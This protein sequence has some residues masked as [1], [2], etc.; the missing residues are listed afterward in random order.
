MLYIMDTHTYIYIYIPAECADPQTEIK[1]RNC[2]DQTFQ[3][4]PAHKTLNVQALL[5]SLSAESR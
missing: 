5:P 3:E 4:S 2:P 1:G